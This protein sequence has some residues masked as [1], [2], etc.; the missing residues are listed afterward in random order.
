MLDFW[1]IAPVKFAWEIG[2]GV[3]GLIRPKKRKL[4]PSEIISLRHKW[5]PLFQEY[6]RD[7]HRQKLRTDV[8]IRDMKRFDNYPDTSDKRGI[9][10]W[11]RVWLA[12]TY[13]RGF[14]VGLDWARLTVD[15]KT[16][17][18]R[19]AN[20]KAGE[21]GELNTALVGYI[22]YE[23]VESVNWDG[24]E[25]YQYPHIFCYFE[26]EKKQPYDRLGFSEPRQLNGH[27]YFTEIADYKEVEKLSKR[28][29]IS[30]Y[31]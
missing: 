15:E 29:G 9:S 19:Y 3:W 1:W 20:R 16:G 17:G 18:W 10:P 24:D 4:S 8:I 12:D 31:G 6:L 28:F 21:S 11:F 2:K 23:F 25:Y 27:E 7:C 30:R 14:V 13:H 5:Q 26:G 22:P